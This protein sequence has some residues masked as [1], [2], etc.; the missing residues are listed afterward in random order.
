[1]ILIYYRDKQTGKIVH[2]QPASEYASM[3]EVRAA[4]ER[5][6]GRRTTKTAQAVFVAP[7]SLYEYL[8]KYADS[9]ISTAQ[10]HIKNALDC[11]REAESFLECLE[12]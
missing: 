5:F 1:M 9:Q 2:H 12:V 11:M 7:G 6:N 10:N 8:L 3:E 4:V